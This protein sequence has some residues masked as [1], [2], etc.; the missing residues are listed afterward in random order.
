MQPAAHPSAEGVGGEQVPPWRLQRDHR[1]QWGWGGPTTHTSPALSE[2]TKLQPL[3]SPV[4][5][6]SPDIL[7]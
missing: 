5:D 2:L 6:T 3:W 4:P 1:Q 7:I